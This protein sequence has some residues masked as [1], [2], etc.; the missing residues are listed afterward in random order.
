MLIILMRRYPLVSALD[1]FLLPTSRGTFQRSTMQRWGSWFQSDALR[2]VSADG[3]ARQ[4]CGATRCKFI[5]QQCSIYS[6]IH[7]LIYCNTS[8][9]IWLPWLSRWFYQSLSKLTNTDGGARRVVLKY[10]RL[11]ISILKCQTCVWAFGMCILLFLCTI[12][13]SLLQHS[14]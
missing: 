4:V 12:F 6:Q 14:Y 13:S 9:Q 8:Y 11:I 1:T 2:G 10:G 7:F 3:T 5:W